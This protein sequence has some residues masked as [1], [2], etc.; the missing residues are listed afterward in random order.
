MIMG[1][2]I[3]NIV[4]VVK[5]S[6]YIGFKLLVV[7]EMNIDGSFD[8]NIFISVD[9]IG[10]GNDEIVLVTNGT[11]ARSTDMTHEKPIDSVIIAKLDKLTFK[12]RELD[13]E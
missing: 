3:G 10:V 5:D 4:S 7:Q 1:K 11:S 6:S 9:L 13:L 12:D 2:V 8:K